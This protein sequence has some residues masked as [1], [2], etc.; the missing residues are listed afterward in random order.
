[1]STSRY[2]NDVPTLGGDRVHRARQR[3]VYDALFGETLQTALGVT[4]RAPTPATARIPE[5]V[6]D[7]QPQQFDLD[8]P[9]TVLAGHWLNG[10]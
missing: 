3:E 4:A 2:I 9:E 10:G 6:A 5:A 1:M 8:T 7:E